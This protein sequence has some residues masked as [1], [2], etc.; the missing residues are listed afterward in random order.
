MRTVRLTAVGLIFAALFAVSAFAQTPATPGKVGL[1][2]TSEFGNDKPGAGINRFVT[3]AKSVDD[4]F[5]TVTAEINT[6]TTRYQTL[7]NDVKKLQDQL[8]ATG[9]PPI[10][11]TA[12]QKQFDAKV[13]EGQTLELTIKRKQEDAKAKYSKRYDQVVGPILNEIGDALNEFAKKNGYAVI[14]DGLKLQEAQ[15]LMGFDDKY[16]VTKEFITYFNART[17]A[18]ASTAKPE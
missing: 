2:N 15:I 7:A 10:D 5:K 3:A 18:T 17:P 13:D 14:L 4:E 6:L 8:G 12:L 1:I 9:G 11:K 16:N